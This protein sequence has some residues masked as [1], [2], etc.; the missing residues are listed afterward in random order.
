ML[1][2]LLAVAVLSAAQ[3]APISTR[4]SLEET[5]Q[6]LAQ[7]EAAAYAAPLPT[8]APSDDVGFVG[9]CLGRV[10]GH[11]ETGKF[12]KHD[13]RELMDL[14]ESERRRFENALAA[15]AARDP[16]AVTTARAA[17]AQSEGLWA[18]VRKKE[19]VWAKFE[20]ETYSG[21]PGRCEHAA[22]RI[23]ANITTPPAVLPAAAVTEQ[24]A[25]APRVLPSA[26]APV[27]TN[28]TPR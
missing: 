18:E 10:A 20:Y 24:A 27:G 2:T 15:A 3:E 11:L 22:R 14:A 23:T 26:D 6:Q 16:Q 5:P 17:Q 12:L 28:N 8:D 19:R 7:R 25:V 9:W 4:K 13:D 1:S 21:L